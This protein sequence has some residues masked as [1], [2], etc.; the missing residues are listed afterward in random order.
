MKAA[1]GYHKVAKGAIGLAAL[2]AG[3]TAWALLKHG[4]DAFN[5]SHPEPFTAVRL[6]FGVSFVIV[7]VICAWYFRLCAKE[8]EKLASGEKALAQ[9]TLTL[10]EHQAFAAEVYERE[11]GANAGALMAVGIL[12][13]LALLMQLII[14]LDW[15]TFSLVVLGILAIWGITGFV[16]PR[17]TRLRML[18]QDPASADV[19]LRMGHVLGAH[20]VWADVEWVKLKRGEAVHIMT[21]RHRQRMWAHRTGILPV[22]RQTYHYTAYVPV[23]LNRY[24]EAVE[25]ARQIAEAHGAEL[26]MEGE[27]R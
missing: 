19:G 12:L 8:A 14:Q 1:S 11:H 13:G 9:W 18:R 3:L 4:E 25:V 26:N 21:I 16:M 6:T 10:T 23:P 27:E 15:G 20:A 7:G 2:G 17:W 24:A 5:L 22:Y